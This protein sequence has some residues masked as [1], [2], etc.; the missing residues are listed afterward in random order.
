MEDP[1]VAIERLQQRLSEVASEIG[2]ELFQCAF[3]KDPQGGNAISAVFT[4]RQEAVMTADEIQQEQTDDIFAEMLGGGEGEDDLDH[5]AVLDEDE[6][7]DPAEAAKARLAAEDTPP[8]PTA[9]EQDWTRREDEVKKKL[10]KWIE[11]GK[12]HWRDG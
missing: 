8:P 12:S 11:D 6:D 4:I 2:L 3:M 10:M 9:E 1:F 7:L 5:I